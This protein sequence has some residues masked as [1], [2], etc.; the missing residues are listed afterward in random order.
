MAFKLATRLAFRSSTP[1]HLMKGRFRVYVAA[2]YKACSTFLFFD[3]A[4]R[5][6]SFEEI[7]NHVVEVTKVLKCLSQDFGMTKSDLAAAKHPAG[8]HYATVDHLKRIKENSF[9]YEKDGLTRTLIKT[10]FFRVAFSLIFIALETSAFEEKLKFA[11]ENPSYLE[12]GSFWSF[13]GKFDEEA[14]NK[15]L[16]WAEKAGVR[17]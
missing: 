14:R 16:K 1:A 15:L 7:P 8:H 5:G 11:S 9:F 2:F 10:L 17:E 12:L 4:S 13:L 6:I 3:G